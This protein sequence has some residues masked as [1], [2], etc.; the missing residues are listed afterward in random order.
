MSFLGSEITWIQGLMDNY[1]LDAGYLPVYLSAYYQAVSQYL[2][3]GAQP[4]VN[5]LSQF[6]LD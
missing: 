5:W 1:G 6:Q 4:V 3:D 2:N